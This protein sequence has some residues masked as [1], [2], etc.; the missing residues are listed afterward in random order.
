M[1]QQFLSFFFLL[2]LQRFSVFL[3]LLGQSIF[4]L[5][6]YSH[7]KLFFSGF[8]NLR[9]FKKLL[10]ICFAKQVCA[11]SPSWE[12]INAKILADDHPV[13]FQDLP[14]RKHPL[15]RR[16]FFRRSLIC[17][18]LSVLLPFVCWPIPT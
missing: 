17:R 5:P 12:R 9:I 11:V 3:F 4:F 16:G 1:P 10:N 7:F 14:A 18:Q 8:P 6:L 13:F 15:F 2:T